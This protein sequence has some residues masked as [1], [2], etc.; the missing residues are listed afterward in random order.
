MVANKNRWT[1]GL[2][3]SVLAAAVSW[4]ASADTTVIPNLIFTLG[5][6]SNTY[7]YQAASI[8]NAWGNG[9]STF[10][11]AG[12]N[13]PA[14]DSSNGFSFAWNLLVNPDPFIIGNIVVTNTSNATQEFM[15]LVTLPINEAIAQTYIGGSI[16]GT[17]TDLN[18]DGATLAAV[19]GGSIYTALTDVTGI[20]GNIAGTLLTGTSVSAGSFLSANV[21]P[22]SFGDPIPN[23][24]YGAVTTNIAV[25]LR[26]TLTAG[27][28]ASFT[29]IFVVEPVPAPGAVALLGLA[30]LAARSR[31]RR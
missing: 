23:Q 12:M 19:N 15:L 25:M 20:T 28:S 29:S 9:N 27:D 30:G 14:M 8:G 3:G 11:Y 6:G 31:R 10:G 16:T 22:A 26:F 5:A 24:L 17:V 13:T 2:G 21:G 4:T 1:L 18:G 7:T